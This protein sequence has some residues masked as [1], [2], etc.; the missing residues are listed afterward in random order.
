MTRP[1]N[2]CIVHKSEYV[3]LL[4]SYSALNFSLFNL[5]KKCDWTRVVAMGV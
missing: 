2:V 4:L 3:V 5:D 1:A